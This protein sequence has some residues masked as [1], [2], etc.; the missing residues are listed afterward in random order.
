MVGVRSKK[1]QVRVARWDIIEINGVKYR[2]GIT[3]TQFAEL[4]RWVFEFDKNT[5]KLP[6]KDA[7]RFMARA[8]LRIIESRQ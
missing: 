3:L 1:K 8:H 7:A 6:L 5:H 4:D 2:A